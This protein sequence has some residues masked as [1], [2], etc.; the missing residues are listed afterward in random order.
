M[1]ESDSLLDICLNIY[2]AKNVL[3]LLEVTELMQGLMGKIYIPSCTGGQFR[4]HGNPI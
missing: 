1:R 2:L 4:E 3:D